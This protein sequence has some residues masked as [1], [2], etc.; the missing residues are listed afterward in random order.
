M[1]CVW[2]APLRADKCV[3]DS[4]RY[5]QQRGWDVTYLP[6]AQDGLV[7]VAQLEAAIRPDTA[8]VSVMYVNNEIGALPPSRVDGLEAPLQLL[9]GHSL[10]PCEGLH[11]S[12]RCQTCPTR[13][14]FHT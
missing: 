13:R 1:T 11:L 10:S 2:G 6:V 4:C 12:M 5:M 7:D 9:Q 8:L 14:C 3:L